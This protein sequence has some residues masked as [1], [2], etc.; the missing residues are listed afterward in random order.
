[1]CISNKSSMIKFVLLVLFLSLVSVQAEA[2]DILY[3]DLQM[4]VHD[5]VFSDINCITQEGL[6]FALPGMDGGIAYFTPLL[7]LE[8]YSAVPNLG[9]VSVAADE[10]GQR[11]F[12]AIGCGSNSDGLY[13]F[14]V[15]THEFEL[16]GWY[17]FPRFVKQLDD[18]YYFGY[19]MVAPECGLLYSED[20]DEWN[21]VPEFMGISV[22]DIEKT[23]SGDL[24]A[25]A[26]NTIYLKHEGVWTS[27]EAPLEINDIYRRWYPH[28]NEVYIAC[29]EGSYSD[30]VYR[31]EYSEGE[32]SG[33]TIINFFFKPYRIYQIENQLLVGCLDDNGLF[34]VEPEE[35]AEPVQLGADLDF[36]EVYCFET[37]PMYCPNFMVGT[38]VGVYLSVPN[39]ESGDECKPV[40][41]CSCY[42][43]PFNPA[44]T[45]SFS[46]IKDSEIELAVYN[47]KG[48]K[49][50]TLAAG[51]YGS[52]KH[53]VTWTGDD[54]RGSV[55]P[56]GIYFYQLNVNG[57]MEVID[58]CLLLK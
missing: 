11:I 1:M 10:S 49:V 24:V 15:T 17:F 22:T 42:P 40:I 4:P 14:D 45:I 3:E 35:M 47:L 18:G 44:T 16:I 48:Q 13:E 37:Y 31:V 7:N 5:M 19:G 27:Y 30:A 57:R 2:L 26:D 12:A 53:Q 43:N 41:E 54:E 46:L 9:A 55:L 29:G 52:G 51:N 21:E 23:G 8:I 58:K 39:S 20:G 33:L 50:K 34:Q 25:A 38:D 56:S 32:I 6:V 28:N 36:T